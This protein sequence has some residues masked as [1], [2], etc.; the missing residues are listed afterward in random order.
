MADYMWMATAAFGLEGI[1]ARELRDLH[2]E[3]V[4]CENGRVTFRGDALAGAKANLW[5][6]CADRV[7]LVMGQFPAKTF[8]E[9]FQGVRALDW[10][11]LLPRDAH[12][13]VARAKSHNSA[14]FSLRDI[15][16]V[17][18]KAMVEAM[19]AAY[20]AS[21]FD[22]TGASFPVEISLKDDIATVAVDASGSGLHRRGYRPIVGE[23]PLRETLAAAMVKIVRYRGDEPFMDPMCGT[24][25]LCLEA[26]MAAY[27]IAPGLYRSFACEKWPLYDAKDF[28][29]LRSEARDLRRR[30]GV[31][32][33]VGRDID[34]RAIETAKRHAQ[35][36]SLSSQ[37]RFE[38]RDVR[39][40]P[41][42][43]DRGLVL[44]NP[45]YGERLLDQKGAALLARETGQS[46]RRHMPDWRVGMLSALESF[47]SD[48]G[49]RPAL[50]RK[51]YNGKLKCYFYLFD[52]HAKN[53][54]KS[55]ASNAAKKKFDPSKKGN[56]R[57]QSKPQTKK[58]DRG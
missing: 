22:E 33:I 43:S 37:I 56:V 29:M 57:Q 2:M 51:L 47:P 49:A 16:S 39:D 17:G 4:K 50:N 21:W 46:M 24:G 41:D 6:R 7:F 20:G 14:L 55:A 18:K 36:A 10:K 44:C 3:D 11:G 28:R 40:L 48:Y 53:G 12:F 30:D 42:R 27:R 5:L 38:V 25:T 23:A 19:K 26:A 45:P 1:V 13:P 32:E 52:A 35:M 15:Q 58:N 9:L 8:E 31:A 34:P 54:G